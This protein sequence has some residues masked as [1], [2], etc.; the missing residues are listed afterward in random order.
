M[1]GRGYGWPSTISIHV[2]NIASPGVNCF[3]LT[4]KL[5]IS[6][7]CWRRDCESETDRDLG[8]TMAQTGD[9]IGNIRN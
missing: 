1:A 7:G 2:L 8:L 3:Q 4:G 5:R 6:G 9:P